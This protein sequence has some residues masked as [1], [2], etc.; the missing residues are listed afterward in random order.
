VNRMAGTNDDRVKTRMVPILYRLGDKDAALMLAEDLVRQ[1]AEPSATNSVAFPLPDEVQPVRQPVRQPVPQPGSQPVRSGGRASRRG[2]TGPRPLHT[3]IRALAD[4]RVADEAAAFAE[5]GKIPEAKARLSA[6][7]VPRFRWRAAHAIASAASAAEAVPLWRDALLEARLVNE[8]SA[9]ITAAALATALA[10]TPDGQ[11][12]VDRL[13]RNARAITKAWTE[14]AFAEQYE[15]LRELL[16]S[17]VGRTRRMDELIAA[18]T[19]TLNSGGQTD[20]VTAAFQ[21]PY[22]LVDASGGVSARDQALFR[23]DLL[24]GIRF[25]LSTLWSVDDVR[26]LIESGRPGKRA[27]AL[28]LM[29]SRADLA[30]LDLVL[31][32]IETSLSAFEQFHA[33]NLALDAAPTLDATQRAQVRAAIER[34]RLRHILPDTDRF[35]LSEHILRALQES[36][37][38]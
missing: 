27:F 14:S 18:A 2:K 24:W 19:R 25:S 34:E 16:A 31:A 29:K 23:S 8:P 30:P 3:D 1:G 36:G 22:Q 37:G 26:A 4:A 33:L 20:W 17:G 12:Q 5:A 7:V 13:T 9:R 21:L 28:A 38:E 11:L 10:E 15:T 6:I 32:L 35:T